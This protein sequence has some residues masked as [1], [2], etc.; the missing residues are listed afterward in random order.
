[1]KMN[2]T[3]ETLFKDYCSVTKLE[4]LSNLSEV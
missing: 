4:I 2:F 3:L 1:M